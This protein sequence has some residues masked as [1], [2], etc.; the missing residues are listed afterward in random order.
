MK[1]MIDDVLKVSVETS[2]KVKT[3]LAGGSRVGGANSSREAE[4]SPGQE[5][6]AKAGEPIGIKTLVKGRGTAIT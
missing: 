6:S 3:A 1:S 2:T 4:G 5:T